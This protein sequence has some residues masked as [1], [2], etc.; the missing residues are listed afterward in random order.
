MADILITKIKTTI[1]T[2]NQNIRPFLYGV[3]HHVHGIEHLDKNTLTGLLEQ[4]SNHTIVFQQNFDVYY[5]TLLKF[6]PST[7]DSVATITNL[8]K[9]YEWYL[10]F[11]GLT[12]AFALNLDIDKDDYPVLRSLMLPLKASEEKLASC[13]N[14]LQQFLLV[15]KPSTTGTMTTQIETEDPAT[16]DSVPPTPSDTPR[17]PVAH[18]DTEHDFE[19]DPELDSEDQNILATESTESPNMSPNSNSIETEATTKASTESP[20]MSPD[21]NAIETEATSEASTELPNMS[22]DSNVIETEATSEASTELPN[23]SPDSNVM[24]TEA[25]SKASTES[26]NMSPDSNVIETEATSEASTELPNMSP[27]SNVI[28]TEATS[29]ASTESPNMSP[30]SYVIETEAPKSDMITV[31]LKTQDTPLNPKSNP[32]PKKTRTPRYKFKRIKKG[33]KVQKIQSPG[34]HK[35]K[36]RHHRNKRIYWSKKLWYANNINHVSIPS[37]LHNFCPMVTSNINGLHTVIHSQNMWLLRRPRVKI[38]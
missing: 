13:Y 20:N 10:N 12:F 1:K 27:D 32:M 30:D 25:T 19:H 3:L 29:K 18:P 21:S 4:A 22:P 16:Q 28:K 7:L 36:S 23:M 2:Y 11:V 33:G 31:D 14:S 17:H 26:P 9:D 37:T 5:Y 8:S 38:K 15:T 34:V 24:E 6:S 35:M